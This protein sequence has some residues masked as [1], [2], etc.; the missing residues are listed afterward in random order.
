MKGIKL[1]LGD[2]L[3]L[4][5][6][7]T[8]TRKSVAIQIKEDLTIIVRTPKG[9]PYRQ[10]ESFVSSHKQWIEKNYRRLEAKKR[11]QAE[12]M[13]VNLYY[14]GAKLP[15]A[16]YPYMELR[17]VVKEGRKGTRISFTPPTLTVEL[18]EGEDLLVK[19]C[20][21]T[22]YRAY[23]KDVM[24]ERAS[25]YATLMGVIY[26]R[27]SIKS[28]KTRWGSCSAKKNLNFNWKLVLMP[29]EILDY[30]V[31]HELA[32]LKQM[33]HSPQFWREVEQILP[34]YRT[35]REWLVKKG[36]EFDR[37]V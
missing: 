16:G 2:T 6:I 11:G 33:N 21:L 37:F 17:V 36:K 8:S 23:A 29:M 22:W 4:V 34:D 28:Q 19:D 27:I 5:T 12:V 18:A 30:V 31:V 1:A 25:Y 20:V 32:H 3:V 10:I 35:K 24:K 14:D 15:L 7:I 26:E 9:M 13:A